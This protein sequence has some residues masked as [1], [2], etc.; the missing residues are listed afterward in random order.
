MANWFLGGWKPKPHDPYYTVTTVLYDTNPMLYVV[1]SHIIYYRYTITTRIH[2]EYGVDAFFAT[3]HMIDFSIT[4]NHSE[5]YSNRTVTD[6]LR[7]LEGAPSK[8][9]CSQKI[10]RQI[11]CFYPAF[12]PFKIASLLLEEVSYC[13]MYY[14]VIIE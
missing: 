5:N 14:N 8:K 4:T 1:Y 6:N 11:W 9:N 10:V 2:Q 7:S 3:W 13:P 12:Y